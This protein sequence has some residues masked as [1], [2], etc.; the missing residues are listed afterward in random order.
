[1][2]S[3]AK[4]N[5]ILGQMTLATTIGDFLSFF[6]VVTLIDQKGLSAEW[7]GIGVVAR[8]FGVGLSSLLVPA[9]LSRHSTRSTILGSQVVAAVMAGIL[10][11]MAWSDAVYV[12]VLLVLLFGQAGLKQAFDVAREKHSHALGTGKD[13]VKN[14]S[15]LVVG[16]Y[17]AQIFGPIVAYFLIKKLSIQ[18]PLAVDFLSFLV[19]AWLAMQLTAFAP[20]GYR[21]LLPD[22]RVI[23]RSPQLFRLI[24]LRSVGFWIGCSAFNFVL[25]S[26]IAE[27]F[28]LDFVS[29]AWIYSA[30]GMGAVVGGQIFRN[31]RTGELSQFGKANEVRLIVVGHVFF[32]VSVILFSVVKNLEWAILL[33]VV[34][35]FGMGVNAVASQALRRQLTPLDDIPNVI[36]AE[37][38]IAR[39]VDGAIG[40][41]CA[42][43][44][45]KNWVS[46]QHL[47]ICAGITLSLNGIGHLFLTEGFE[48]RKKIQLGS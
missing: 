39:L 3:P 10:L 30:L 25:F 42:M 43:L 45:L 14:Q 23:G 8:S 22:F 26:V 44:I 47:L 11:I 29:S 4:E 9:V 1:M 24:M 13:H 31:F 27:Q 35:G 33:F 12:G 17:L 19:T 20:I 41:I 38:I 21:R 46:P 36:A 7:A 5:Q 16:F 40:V 34:G 15:Q 28:N 2:N 6:A 32:A 37:A 48:L 18:L